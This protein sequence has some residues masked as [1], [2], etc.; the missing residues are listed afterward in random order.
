MKARIKAFLILFFLLAMILAISISANASKNYVSENTLIVPNTNMSVAM[1]ISDS[2]R[3][4][5]TLIAENAEDI[6][7]TITFSERLSFSEIEDYLYK[8]S[9][10]PEMLEL[11]G[12]T[13]NGER[14]TIATRVDKGLSS[15]ES[16]IMSMA[17]ESGFDVAGIISL[18][19]VVDA[20]DIYDLRNDS[21]TYFVD[22]S[23]EQAS[24]SLMAKSSSSNTTSATYPKSLAWELEDLGMIP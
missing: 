15:T 19:G 22:T 18:N 3:L 1:Y 16:I 21:R 11:R 8:H 20:V 12:F 14:V 24:I 23:A 5:E 10:V 7:V 6:K 13:P 17:E 2:E 9:I 4:V